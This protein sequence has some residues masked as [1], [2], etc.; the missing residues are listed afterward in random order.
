LRFILWQVGQGAARGRNAE[1]T[2]GS[3]LKNLV[4]ILIALTSFALILSAPSARA[5][6]R[7][8]EIHAH[9]FEFVP[10]EITVKKGETVT[11]SLISDDVTHSL[12]IEA[13]GI[14]ATIAK[15]HPAQVQITPQQAGD[16]NGRCGRFCGSGHGKM[17]FVLHVTE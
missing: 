13:L 10:S 11:L 5:Q 7:T 12:F 14:N 16:F 4:L 1:T 8:I 9:R 15:G 6:Q 2:K 3:R 17:T